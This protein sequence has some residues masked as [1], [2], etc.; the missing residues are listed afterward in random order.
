MSTASG[1]RAGMGDMAVT[2]A[3]LRTA[4]FTTRN[5]V[6]LLAVL[7]MNYTLMRPSPVD[8]L[9]ITS[10][11]LTLFYMA[12]FVTHEVTRRFVAFTLLLA[13][14]AVSFWVASAPHLGEPN[15]SFELLAKSFAIMIGTIGAFVSMS[16]NRRHFET[17]MKVYILSGVVASILGTIGFVLQTELLTW[18]G[19]AKGFIDDPNMYG[20]FL[21]PAVLFCVYFLSRPRESK[22]LL[23]G[24]ML[25]LG[26]GILLSFSRIAIVATLCC[27]V[28]H[29]FFHNRLHPRRLLLMVGGLVVI[30]L[31][32]FALASVASAE[33]SEKLLERLTLAKSYDLGEEGRYGRYLLV[34]PMILEN[35][36]GLGVLQLEK[37]FPEPIHNIWLS[38][39]VNYGWFAG[40]TW[41]VLAFASVVVSIRN[42]RRTRSDIT[43]ALMISLIGIVMCSTLHEGEHW[44]HLWLFFGLVWGFNALKFG[45]GTR[46][47]AGGH[48]AARRS[49]ARPVRMTATARSRSR[50]CA[51]LD[52]KRL[53]LAG[54][55]SRAPI[56]PSRRASHERGENGRSGGI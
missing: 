35:P 41:I 30:G 2:V 14:W 52:A 38:S 34:L 32:L 42:Y 36:L 1:A 47:A 19:R 26:L 3:G 50:A 6:F 25:L 20:S 21:L 56:A 33:F 48:D 22:M 7:A 43:I 29:V 24:A 45:S 51:R 49:P 18:D 28:A 16:W 8:M 23:V 31:V 11:L 9:F 37:V 15:V 55:G 39:F 5:F 46:L 13:G 44:R 54:G 10:F 27:L 53:V 17:F 4:V 40:F 12:L